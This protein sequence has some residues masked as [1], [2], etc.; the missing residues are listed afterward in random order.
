MRKQIPI[1]RG[2]AILAVV[3]YHCAAWGHTAM[4]FWTHRFRQVQP[5]NYDQF[6]SIAYYVLLAI[7]RLAWFSVP[8]F[9][10]ISGFSIAYAASG[11]GNTVSW[12]TIRSRI[13]RLAFPYFIWS[14][15]IFL[16]NGVFLGTWQKPAEYLGRLAVGNAEGLY[17]FVP[18]LAQFYILSPVITRLAKRRPVL[19]LVGAAAVQTT[20]QYLLH[21]P[22][23]GI[24]Y[25]W[26]FFYWAL[27][28]PLGAIVFLHYQQARLVISRLKWVALVVAVCSWLYSVREVV[29]LFSRGSGFGVAHHAVRFSSSLY[30]LA[31]IAAFLG[32]DKAKIPLSGFLQWLGARSYGLYLLHFTVQ[33]ALSKFIYR[34]ASW[35]LGI[36]VLYQSVLLL[37]GLG[38]PIA[39][40]EVVARSPLRKTYRYLFGAPPPAPLRKKPVSRKAP[41]CCSV[42]R[43]VAF[44]ERC[45]DDRGNG[46]L[47]SDVC[48]LWRAESE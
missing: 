26:G 14:A 44:V 36:Q 31:F 27:L 12:G 38:L 43:T 39:F 11:A 20:M 48:H 17:Y 8:A 15:A 47:R 25:P 46:G 7:E 1:L 18:L 6:R 35:L 4:F 16:G 40:M 3:L 33:L 23:G 21:S 30:A 28:F 32:F 41:T 10:F 34:Y 45:A 24:A 29:V 42:T 13:S 2:L 37:A 22:G 5:P 19:L 9:L